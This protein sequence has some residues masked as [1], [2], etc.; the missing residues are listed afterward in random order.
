MHFST[1]A[2]ERVMNFDSSSAGSS[3][4]QASAI[5]YLAEKH[6]TS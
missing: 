3:T 2:L 4:P 6:D 1:A 5:D